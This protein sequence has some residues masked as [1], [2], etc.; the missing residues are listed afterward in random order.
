MLIGREEEEEEIERSRSDRVQFPLAALGRGFGEYFAIMKIGTP[1]QS[2]ALAIDTGSQ[3]LWLQCEPCIRCG[4]QAQGYSVYNP[5]VSKTYVPFTCDEEECRGDSSVATACT[6][7]TASRIRT[8]ASQ[9]EPADREARN[10][11]Q[12]QLDAQPR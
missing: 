10:P 6:S 3:L 12:H 5:A 9:D 8:D 7:R 4:A 11:H 2:I 1:P